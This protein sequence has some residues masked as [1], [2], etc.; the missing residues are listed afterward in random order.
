MGGRALRFLNTLKECSIKIVGLAVKATSLCYFS[1]CPISKL[2]V[3]KLYG[4]AQNAAQIIDRVKEPDDII[5]NKASFDRDTI[6]ALP[7]YNL[8]AII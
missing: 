8:I 1:W 2:G 5:T 3:L 4:A 6:V 7:K